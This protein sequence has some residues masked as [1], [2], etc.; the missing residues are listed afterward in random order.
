MAYLVRRLLENTSSESFLLRSFGADRPVEELL[1]APADAGP[2]ESPAQ[3]RAPGGVATFRNEPEADFSRPEARRSM[4]H[5]LGAVRAR[6]GRH[7]PLVIGGRDVRTAQIVASLDPSDPARVVGTVSS[8]TAADAQAAVAAAER[9]YPA[10]AARAADDRAACLFRAAARMRV[11]RHE[12]AAWQVYEVGK[13]WREADADV[14]EAIDYLEYY[15]REAIRL[16]AELSFDVPGE[17]NRYGYAPLGVGLAVAP[18]NFPLAI[19]AGMTSAALAAGNCVIMKPAT[20]SAVIGA[21]LM[22]VFREADLPAGVLSYVPG[23]GSTVGNALI[24]HP[25]VRFIAF[26]GSREVGLRIAAAAA[27]VPKGARGLKRLI[28]EMGGKNAIVVDDDADLDEAVPGVVVS[29][30]GYGGQKCSACSRVVVLE[31]VYDAFV[32]RLVEAARSIRIGPPAE[33]DT[34]LG[35]LVTAEALERTRGY[36]HAGRA[37][38][39]VALDPEEAGLPEVGYYHAPAIFVDVPA[40]ARIAR[41][42]IFGPVLSVMRARDLDQAFSVA[43]DTDYALTAG[44]Y[45]RSP[46]HIERARRELRCGNLYI[47]RKITGAIVGRQPFGG[48]DMSGIGSKAGGPDYLAQFLVPRTVSENVMR[49]GFVPA[50]PTG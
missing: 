32:S 39:R 23:P 16:G 38:A 18:W 19:L 26:T 21:N 36:V 28:C 5:A 42:E 13:S 14:V 35:P 9:A 48:F 46:S 34:W 45:T 30:F 25:A 15:A 44:I 6:L 49:R 8:A 2:P 10:W 27:E 50:D 22:E 7:Y 24:A 4:E 43:N 33:A 3:E 11:R 47:N 37:E 12:L 1:R 41:E 29:A 17:T 20:P 40:E 31:S